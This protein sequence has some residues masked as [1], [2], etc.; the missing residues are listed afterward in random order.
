MMETH[1]SPLDSLG[2]LDIGAT[3]AGKNLIVVGATGFLGKVWLAMLLHRYP[4]IGK[5]YTV[6]RSRKRVTSEERWWSELVPS[7]AFDPLREQHPGKA[8]EQFMRDKVVPMDGDWSLPGPRSL[9]DANPSALDQPHHDYPAWDWLI[10]V[11]TP[12]Y[13]VRGGRVAVV[14]TWPYNWW[15]RGCGS[16][17]GGP[18]GRG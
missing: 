16:E 5:L 15:N 1:D 10:P 4:Q 7:P 14:R 18:Q 8:Y 9:I 12:I 6:V 11:G 3:L 17:G 13:A 2:P